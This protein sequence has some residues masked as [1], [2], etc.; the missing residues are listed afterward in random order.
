MG[1][2][3]LCAFRPEAEAEAG[4]G[5]SYSRDFH[6]ERQGVPAPQTYVN[7]DGTGAWSRI[8][9]RFSPAQLQP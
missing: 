2:P 6:P 4:A 1:S 3:G 8:S 5:T 9:L 7:A